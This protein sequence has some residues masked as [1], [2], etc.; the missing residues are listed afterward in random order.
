MRRE[1]VS[2]PDAVQDLK[3]LSARDG[4]MR[5]G[6]G[7]FLLCLIAGLLAAGALVVAALY[8]WDLIVGVTQPYT[9][10]REAHPELGA[11]WPMHPVDNPGDW[12][13]NGLVPLDANGDDW[14]DYVTNYEFRGRLR[15]ALHPG[16]AL[17]PGPWPA[18]D[19][20]RVPN[21]EGV[22]VG[23][24]DGDGFPEI[25]VA[26][27]VEHT[28]QAPGIRVLWG[29]GGTW[30]DGGDLAASQGGWHFLSV[31]IADLDRDG[32][33]DIIAGGR[34]S[35]LAG[36]PKGDGG[37][38]P[39]LVWAGI[40]WFE[41][42]GGL[43]ARDLV[44]WSRHELDPD[45]WSGHGFALGDLDG[46]GDLDL[47]NANADWD[48]PDGQERVVWYE[49][50]GPGEAIHGLWPV[51]ELYRS[52]EFY[53]KEQVVL[54]D[55]DGDGR[56][57]LV[58]TSPGSIYWFRNRGPDPASGPVPTFERVALPKHAAA[59]WPARALEV[60]DLNGD[61]RL[62][63][64]GVLIHDRGSL[65]RD[66]A[67]VFWMEQTGD[68]WRTHVIKWGDGF[69]GLGRFNGEKWDQV[70]ARDVDGDGDL[71]LVAN[72][73]EYNRLRAVIAVVWFENPG[74]SVDR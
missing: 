61:G 22:A 65:P 49:N 8:A 34:A 1:V 27:G 32:D 53:G 14:E 35:R 59:R 39:S 55:L 24:L 11:E 41:N 17:G 45:A 54:A 72:C 23:D 28:R 7:R 10:R 13:P 29:Q 62:D 5:T 56:L 70:L 12:L 19:V 20:G 42:P 63:I 33:L 71:D 15:V 21:A 73:E 4:G 16:P 26:H 60:A 68:G 31:E 52:S 66:R 58:T 6:W 25:V 48:T 36:G 57:D 67:A 64:V 69:R 44:A 37:R 47:A 51:H 9:P 3:G 43:S 38:D 74:P 2:A 18:V 46:D 30:E 40:R 50:P